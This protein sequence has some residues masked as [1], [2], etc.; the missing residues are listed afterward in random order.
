MDLFEI[1][2]RFV[3]LLNDPSVRVFTTA[4]SVISFFVSI[5]AVRATT[6]TMA[7]HKAS[8]RSEQARFLEVQWSTIDHLTVSNPDC[9]KLAVDMF[10]IENEV[11]AKREAL[12]YMYLNVLGA[13]FMGRKNRAID[14]DVYDG[15]MKFFFSNYK[16]PQDYLVRLIRNG[17]FLPGFEAECVRYMNKTRGA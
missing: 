17:G 8:L 6:T 10:G 2:K 1:W 14:E 4:L 7:S 9:A 11:E 16:G 13:A 12:H 5:W 3:Q 15:H